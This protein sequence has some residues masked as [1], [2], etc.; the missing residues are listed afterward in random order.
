MS[1]KSSNL[2]PAAIAKVV[3]VLVTAGAPLDRIRVEVDPVSGKFVV[4]T[5]GPVADQ[6]TGLDSWMKKHARQA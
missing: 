1:G 4:A 3:K 2:R 5:T 6:G